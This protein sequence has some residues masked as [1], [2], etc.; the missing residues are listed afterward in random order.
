MIRTYGTDCNQV[1]NVIVAKGSNQQVFA[2]IFDVNNAQQEAQQLADQVNGNWGA[3]NTVNVGNEQVNNGQ[4]SVDQ[5]TGAIASVR[6][7]LRGKGYQGPVVT[8]DTAVAMKANIGLCK[9]SDY[10]AINCHAFFDGNVLPADAGKFVQ[11]W[12]GQIQDLSGG[13]DVVVTESGWPN[14]GSANGKAI[15]S[16]ANQQSALSSLKNAFGNNLILYSA[17]DNKWMKDSA[18]TFNAEKHWG[19][20]G[21][22]PSDA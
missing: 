2:G 14:S 1:A 18:K 20:L 13:K 5:V 7:F 6:S 3:I 8:V 21:N 17:F 4:A 11:G 12:V 22:A 19:I 15:P 16:M 10:C 9:A